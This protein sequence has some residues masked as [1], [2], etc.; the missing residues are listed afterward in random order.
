MVTMNT[1]DAHE[2]EWND[3][4]TGK[5]SDYQE[6]DPLILEAIEGLTPGTALDVGCGAG[7]LVVAL[8]QRGW[9][10]TGIDIAPK[11]IAATRAVLDARNLHTDL[12]VAD[13]ATWLPLDKY[14]LIT[15]SFALPTTKAD[16]V[17]LYR[18][19]RD[20]LAPGGSVVI[21]DFD[22]S[23]TRHAA[24]SKFHCPTVEELLAAFDG[25]EIMR[26]EVVETPTHSHGGSGESTD[27]PWTAAF[28]HARRMEAR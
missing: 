16:Q 2:F 18:M 17:K 7:G 5:A 25:L 9:Q 11:A 15:N 19:M 28:L 12:H 26:A 1:N 3:I 22:A 27:I 24:F 6:P 21:K 13:A 14:D 4:Y 20:A 8:L 23:M 10:V